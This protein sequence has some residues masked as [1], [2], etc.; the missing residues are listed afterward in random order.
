MRPKYRSWFLFLVL[1]VLALGAPGERVQALAIGQLASIARPEST[2]GPVDASIPLDR[3]LRFER[4]TLENGLSQ[5]S[6]LAILQDRQ[7]YLW[8]GTQDG[9]NR[10]DGYHFIAFH[11]EAD[12]LSSISH[13]SVISLLEDRDGYIWIG[14]WGGGLNRYDPATGRFKRYTHNPE[15]PTSLSN[16]IVA[17]LFQDSE[18]RLWVGTNGGGLNLYDPQTGGFT[19]Y[20]HN[21]EQSSSLSSDAISAIVADPGGALWLGTGGFGIPGAG[22][23]RFDPVTGTVQVYRHDPQDAGTLSSDTISAIAPAPDGSLWIG[24]GGYALSG[25][26]LNRF[27]PATGRVQR[28]IP[29]AD[30]PAALNGTDILA[31]FLDPS[32][33]LWIALYGAGLDRI[34]LNRLETGFVHTRNDPFNPQSISSDQIWGLLMD[35]SGVMWVGSVN[36]G[37]NKLNPQ[38]QRFGLFRN[39]PGNENSLSYNVIGPMIEDERGGIWIGTYGGG[40]NHYQPATGIFTRHID[41]E[42]NEVPIMSL[43]LARGGRLWQGTLGGLVVYDPATGERK[44]YNHDPQRP[45]SLVQDSVAAILADQQERIWIATLGGLDVYNPLT[46]GFIHVQVPD[47]SAVVTLYL[48]PDN[49]LWVGTWGN[50]LFRLDPATFDNGRIDSKRFVNN[51]EDTRTLNDNAVWALR[52][53]SQGRLWVGTGKGLNRFN[54]ESGTFRSFDKDDGL[55]NN[56]ALCIL[57]DETHLWVSTNSGLARIDPGD[58]TFRIYDVHDGLQSNEFDSGSCLQTRSGEMLF[59]GVN[60]LN[61]FRPEEIQDNPNPPPV[62][63]S[64]FR[65]FNEPIAVNLADRTP[66]RLS[67]RQNFI[68]FEFT[69]LDFRAPE[70]NRFMYMLEGFDRTWVEAGDRRYAGYTNLGGGNYIFRVRAANNDGVWNEDGVSIPLR[71]EPPFWSTWWFAGLIGLFIISVIGAA[72]RWRFDLVRSQ[73]RKLEAQVDERTHALRETNALLEIE[74]EQRFRAEQALARKAERD[75]RASEARFEAMFQNADISFGLM[76]LDRQVLEVNE[77]ACRLL[78]LTKEEFVELRVDDLIHPDDVGQDAEMFQEL[79]DGRRGSYVADKRYRHK[80]GHYIWARLIFSAVRGEDGK[81]AY[82]IGMVEDISEQKRIEEELQQREEEY[83][84]QLEKRVWERTTELRQTNEQLSQEMEQRVRAEAAL[85]H[86]AADEAVVA[87]RNRLARDLHDAVTQTLFSASLVAEVLPELM[88]IDPLEGSKRL[89]E[90]RQLTRGALAEMR[91][92]LFELRPNALVD[93]PLPELLR[94]LAEAT[95]GRAR[96]PVSFTCQGEGTLPPD[97]QVTLYRMV[98]EAL[99][100]VIKYARAGEAAINLR[101]A[102]DAAR[103]MVIDNGIG[104]DPEN[105][106][107][108]HFGLKIMRERA[109]AVGARMSI[110]SEPGQGTQITIHWTVQKN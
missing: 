46:D 67:Y 19:R 29:Q 18:G 38:M 54:V 64:T 103:I 77:A 107:S 100:N 94:Q 68:A 91:T 56:N 110:Y 7:G 52:Q 105:I 33:V 3:P 83:L 106:P 89:Q 101:L 66:I 96:L 85:A 87:E 88:K 95:I 53:D 84:R 36:G 49:I 47:L 93:I 5:N 92:L 21:P 4:F 44:R 73:N 109:E 62:V 59:G 99:N 23:N 45:G 60:G 32:G 104:F 1:S 30:D 72:V 39:Q 76:G 25:A 81:P 27:D 71:I 20:T 78:G 61:I 15:D 14:T 8:I 63:I 55:P 13:N 16:D 65:I 74:I 70:K 34:D 22:L 51:P 82:L 69:A 98:Q 48:D 17:A 79:V 42:R 75:L 43:Y 97:V 6:V 41:P 2:A 102:P 80:D 12:N 58:E 35:R 86:K 50:G 24:T 9:L 108:G 57:A 26:G 11:H 28:F 31:L 40:L 37:L 90:L 10:Y